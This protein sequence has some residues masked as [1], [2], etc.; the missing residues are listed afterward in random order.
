MKRDGWDYSASDCVT[1]SRWLG[2]Y[3]V[4]LPPNQR[5]LTACATPGENLSQGTINDFSKP[6]SQHID[7]RRI[8]HREM[9]SVHVVNLDLLL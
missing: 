4:S 3:V 5:K 6:R 2:C 9:R 1:R 7:L 8:K